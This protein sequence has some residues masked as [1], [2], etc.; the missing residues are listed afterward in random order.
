MKLAMRWTPC[1]LPLLLVAAAAACGDDAPGDGGR[2]DAAPVDVDVSSCGTIG[3]SCSAGCT[4]NLECVDG[5]CL[6][7]RGDCGGFAGAECQDAS[8]LCTYPTGSSGGIC[9]S[10]A[11]KA[12]VCAIAPMAVSDC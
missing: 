1:L 6:P 2:T 7:V 9:M 12:C 10:A 5:R 8:L 4:G 11:E 3:T